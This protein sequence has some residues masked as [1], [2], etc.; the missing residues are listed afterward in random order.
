MLYLD[1]MLYLC[2]VISLCYAISLCHVISFC[3]V[4]SLCRGR[5]GRDHMVVGFTTTRQSVFIT[6]DVVSSNLNQGE[7]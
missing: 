5:H 6:N 4:I 1:V 7:L 3:Y 2:Y